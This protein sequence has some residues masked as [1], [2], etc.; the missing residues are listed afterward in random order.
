MEQSE[1]TFTW[2]T[3]KWKL[4]LYRNLAEGEE[5]EIIKMQVVFP[6]ILEYWHKCEEPTEHLCCNSQVSALHRIFDIVDGL[7]HFI[8][9]LASPFW[10]YS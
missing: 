4:L 2:V 10:G 9:E 5:Y 6:C 7:F 1:K 8:L 3:E